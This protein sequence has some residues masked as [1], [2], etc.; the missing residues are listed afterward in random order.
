VNSGKGKEDSRNQNA[1]SSPDPM[2][3]AI[4]HFVSLFASLFLSISG[5]RDLSRKE[6]S[7]TAHHRFREA[8]HPTAAVFRH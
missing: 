6:R 7:T 3:M 1:I 4:Y 2:F 8:W 5:F